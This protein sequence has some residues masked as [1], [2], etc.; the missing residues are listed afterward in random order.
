MSKTVST[1]IL[2]TNL[3]PNQ[4]QENIFF[5][6]L[7][8]TMADFPAEFV[9]TARSNSPIQVVA[10]FSTQGSDTNAAMLNIELNQELSKIVSD[11][12]G[13]PVLDFESFSNRV[14]NNLNVH[15]CNFIVAHGGQ[16]LRTSMTMAVIEGDTLRMIHIGNAKAVLIRDG[17]IMALTEEQTVAQRYVQM[18]A[19][20]PEQEVNHPD[21]FTLT[22]YLGKMPQDGQVVADKKVHLKLK[23]GDSLCLMGIGI[24]KFLPARNRNAVLIREMSTEAKAHELINTATNIGIKFGLSFAIVEIES[25][26]ILPGDAVIA[27]RPVAEPVPVVKESPFV[28][29]ADSFEGT[30]SYSAFGDVIDN[31]QSNT[32]VFN[33][34]V[35]S[36]DNDFVPASKSGSGKKSSIAG[37]I[38]RSVIIFILCAAAGYGI[39]F[40]VFKTRGMIDLSAKPSE[41]YVDTIL[42]SVGDDIPVYSQASE[43]ATPIGT[44]RYGEGVS[45]LEDEGAYSKIT[46]TGGITGYV[47]SVN[48]TSENP[49]P[50]AA[51]QPTSGDVQAVPSDENVEFIPDADPNAGEPDSAA[52]VS[53]TAAETAEAQVDEGAPAEEA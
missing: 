3:V 2:E 32:T 31:D 47:L 51:A 30:S 34:S 40:L 29:S 28:G 45:Y 36:S 8:R 27:K 22:Q 38:I 4:P 7:Y 13:Q 50:E 49:N 24:S 39:M 16:P 12:N 44:L 23:D 5:H 25:T 19:I 43:D 15:V 11:V 21:R 20:S 17:K 26:L 14:I 53:D 10:L 35:S 1:C 9:R 42:Y 6:T 18:G 46:T 37:L 52:A 41:V 48:L 33:S